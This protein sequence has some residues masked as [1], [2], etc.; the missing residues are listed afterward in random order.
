MKKTETEQRFEKEIYKMIELRESQKVK[1]SDAQKIIDLSIN[2]LER[3]NQ[4]KI[5]RDKWKVKY[6]ELKDATKE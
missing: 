1:V 6:Q 4:I 3:Y 2:L 5:S